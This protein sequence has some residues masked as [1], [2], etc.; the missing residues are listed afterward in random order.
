MGE[1]LYLRTYL[2]GGKNFLVKVW[3]MKRY[4]EEAESAKGAE[5]RRRGIIWVGV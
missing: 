1:Q 4:A 2:V 3:G 5:K